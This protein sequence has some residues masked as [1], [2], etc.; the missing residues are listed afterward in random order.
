[1]HAMLPTD[2]PGADR[3]STATEL[4]PLLSF[5]YDAAAKI[6]RITG[7]GKWTV[8]YVDV[9]FA[10]LAVLIDRVRAQHGAVLALVDLSRAPVQSAEV[11]ERIHQATGQLY[12]PEDRVAMVVQ[13]FLLKAQMKRAAWKANAAI[14]V[15]PFAAMTWLCAHRGS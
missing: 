11:A 12:G 7:V 9:H 15:S 2:H 3:A 8:D 5:S 1:M 10:E 13:S 4:R 14:F 6:I